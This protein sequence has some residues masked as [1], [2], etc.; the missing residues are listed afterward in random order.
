M[1]EVP[2]VEQTEDEW[3]EE[4]FSEE[5]RVS[6]KH[7]NAIPGLKQP[8]FRDLKEAAEQYGPDGILE[9]A[10]HLPRAD[11]EKLEAIVKKTTPP[12]A[13]RRRKKR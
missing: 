9:S 3:R 13:P 7:I 5:E 10:M 6:D 8:S 2:E 4:R 11:F 12:K 1:S